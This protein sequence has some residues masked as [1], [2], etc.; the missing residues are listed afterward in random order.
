MLTLAESYV[1][2]RIQLSRNDDITCIRLVE[3]AEGIPGHRIR[4]IV[5]KVA[6]FYRGCVPWDEGSI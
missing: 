1:N 2:S 4:L 3:P 5:H 6:D